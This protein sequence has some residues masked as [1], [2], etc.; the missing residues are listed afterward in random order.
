MGCVHNALRRVPWKFVLPAVML[1]ATAAFLRLD[2]VWMRGAAYWDDMPVTSAWGFLGLLNGPGFWLGQILR[3]LIGDYVGLSLGSVIFWA[4]SGFLIDR[5]LGGNRTPIIGKTWIRVLLHSL[6]LVVACLALAG[7]VTSL[8]FAFTDFD[9]YSP[10][11]MN[12]FRSKSPWRTLLGRDVLA[13]AGIVWGLGY[14]Q[15][16]GKKLLSFALGQATLKARR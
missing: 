12:T 15:Y 13:I 5:R 8:R 10:W 16:F 9:K 3:A 11:M 2:A 1:T 7:A 6:G 4:Y 14:A